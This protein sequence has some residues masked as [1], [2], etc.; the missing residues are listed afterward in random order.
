MINQKISEDHAMDSLDQIETK[1]AVN[2]IIII[3]VQK[4][5]TY[6]RLILG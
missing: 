6:N 2:S 3:E 5:Y 1:I 4:E